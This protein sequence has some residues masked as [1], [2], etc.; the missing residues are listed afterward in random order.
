[1]PDLIF[2]L[3]IEKY[4]AK[5]TKMRETQKFNIFVQQ[6]KKNIKKNEKIRLP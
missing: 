6:A 3:F 5:V 1:M 2:Q 4:Q